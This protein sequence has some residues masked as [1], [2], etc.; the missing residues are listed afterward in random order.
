M[1][2]VKRKRKGKIKEYKIS[3]QQHPIAGFWLKAGVHE[4]L[5][6]TVTV[7]G[8]YVVQVMGSNVSSDLYKCVSVFDSSVRPDNW[9][10]N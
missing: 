1:T 6:E 10:H 2:K 9:R 3:E 7:E 8:T 5:E 4:A